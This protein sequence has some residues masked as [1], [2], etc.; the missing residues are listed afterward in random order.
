MPSPRRI[1]KLNMLLSE[2][3]SKI[4]DREIEFSEGTL[5]TLTR[6]SVSPDGDF[7]DMFFS[8]FGE[9]Q[10][11]KTL[12][13]L[14]KNL[15]TIQRLLVKAVRMRPVPKVRFLIDKGEARREAVEK[16]LAGIK[17]R[18]EVWQI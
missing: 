11:E 9:G 5:V 15:Y 14:Q 2:E 18:G 10:K 13:I 7:A 6:V 12:E 8:V 3:L 4:I 16:S 1:E 17:K